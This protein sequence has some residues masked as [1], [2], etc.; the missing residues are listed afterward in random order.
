MKRDPHALL[1][2]F[3]RDREQL[4]VTGNALLVKQGEKELFRCYTGKAQKDTLYRVYSMT[5]PVT[6]TAA[7]QLFE[8]GAFNLD[9]PLSRYI[10]EYRDLTVWD[11]NTHFPRPAKAPILIRDLFRMSAGITYG[12]NDCETARQV[13]ALQNRFSCTYPGESYS[14]LSFVRE[15]AGIPLAFEPGAHWRYSLCHDVLGGL[16]EVLSGQTLGDYMHEHIFSPLQMK[17]TFFRCPE[18]KAHRILPADAPGF[19]DEKYQPS[20]RYESG[21]GGL[22]S[23]LDDYMLFSRALTRG[24]IGENGQRILKEETVEL[25]RQDQLTEPMK[26]DFNWDYL[27]GYSYGLGMRTLLFP[28]SEGIPG[29]KGEFGWCGVL[30]TWVLMDP[31]EDLTCVYMHQRFPNLEKYVQLSLRPMVYDLIGKGSAEE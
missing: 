14:T 28:G 23:T 30:G 2:S 8:Q 27:H 21:G 19:G 18:E 22:L 13:S 5:K 15:L 25:M 24:G 20:A 4:P 29:S 3:L 12:G 7:M 10:P 6:V 16:I 1:C 31:K 26:Q 9:E 11:E 17:D